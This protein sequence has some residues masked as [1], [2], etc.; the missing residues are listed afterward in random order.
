MEIQHLSIGMKAPD[1]TAVTTQGPVRLSDYKGKW[2]VFFS[3]PGDFTLVLIDYTPALTWVGC[4]KT[5]FPTSLIKQTPCRTDEVT[6]SLYIVIW[7][8]Q[9]RVWYNQKNP[10]FCNER[11]FLAS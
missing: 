9:C 4:G 6:G 11:C 7:D 8:K 1:F 5:V 2:V 10:L 3:H